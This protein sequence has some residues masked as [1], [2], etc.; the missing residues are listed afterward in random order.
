MTVPDTGYPARREAEVGHIVTSLREELGEWSKAVAVAGSW[1]KQQSQVESVVRILS[2]GLD[3]IDGMPGSDRAA[4]APELVLDLHHVWD[5]MRGKLTQRQILRYK[6]FLD[7]AD[8]LAWAVYEPVRVAANEQ[9]ALKEPPL[10]FLSREPVP[11]AAARGSGFADLLPAGGLRTRGGVEA[12]SHLPFPVI[13][14]PWT[15]NRHLPAV[16]VIAHETGHHLEDDFTLGPSLRT[17]LSGAGLPPERAVAWER[18]LGEV[19]ADV[20][21]TLAC[22][23]AYVWV[24]SDAL[25]A[26]G[27]ADAGS[28]AGMER[29]PPARLR[30]MAC[31]AALAEYEAGPAGRGA[32]LAGGGRSLAGDGSL[33]TGGGTLAGGGT[34]L[35][36]LPGVPD[37]S[38]AEADLVV[39]ALITKGFDQL[40]GATLGS[41]IGIRT[42]D[43]LVTAARRLLDGLSTGRT[44]VPGVLSA[45]ALAFV[46]DPQ[47]YDDAC[48]GRRAMREVLRLVPEG[49]RAAAADPDVLAARDSRVGTRLI[50]LLSAVRP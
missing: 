18:W 7:V 1:D 47:G 41:L 22:G 9:L 17:R 16:L 10:T 2:S 49:P 28:G 44:D 33:P 48:V 8:E 23:A 27:Q 31:R 43:R 6:Q 29:Y 13:G 40:G 32:A 34:A 20:C 30:L 26:A 11:F 21:A 19:F 35:P 37:A 5:F 4:K 36:E 24:L 42:P 12:S 38:D 50:D 3:R 46:S 39:K 14:V 45:A 15:A 25:A